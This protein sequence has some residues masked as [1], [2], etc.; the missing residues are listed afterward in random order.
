MNKP[1]TIRLRGNPNTREVRTLVTL[2]GRHPRPSQ[3]F[4]VKTTMRRCSFAAAAAAA[5]VTCGPAAAQF[6]SADDAI[7]YRQGALAVMGHHF[8]VIGGMI[9]GKT[10]FDAKTAQA[11]ADL[12]VTLSRLPWSAFVEGSDKGDTSAKPEVWAQPDKFKAAA[13]K[14]QDAAVKLD[15]AAAKATKADDLKAAFNAT[16]DTCKACHDDFRKKH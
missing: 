10:P 2:L 14:F 6:K 5:L 8:G 9:S 12:V 7:E 4:D 3:D 11:N 16:A 1:E 13:A 15:A